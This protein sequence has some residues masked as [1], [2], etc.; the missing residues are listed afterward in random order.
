MTHETNDSLSMAQAE[1]H[2]LFG[3][4]LLRLQG[5]ERL[6]KAI[7]SHHSLSGPAASLPEAQ[8]ARAADIGRQT[9]GTLAGQM[10]GSLI[11]ADGP[12][13]QWKPSDSNPQV[14]FRMHIILPP[15]HFAKTEVELRDLVALRNR[16]VHHFLDEHE[17]GSTG[18]CERARIALTESSAQIAQA[19]HNLR[20]WAQDLEQMRSRMVKL[21]GMDEMW[22]AIFEGE[23][24]WPIT[25]VVQALREAEAELA[26]DGWASVVKAE[27]WVSTHHPDERPTGYRCS[28][29]RQVIHESRLFDLRHRTIDGRHEAWYR[30]KAH[31]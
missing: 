14:A 27:E 12:R 17:L 9:L 21:L 30:S 2:R 8:A 16:L 28:S 19:A 11:V 25:T 7:L 29:W 3:Q 23:I 10:M 24:P 20:I 22:D 4:C 31:N 26:I 18:G 5:Y 13:E 1:V 15:E 6:V